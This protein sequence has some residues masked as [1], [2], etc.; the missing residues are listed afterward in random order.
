[1]GTNRKV[2]SYWRRRK[3]PRAFDIV[4]LRPSTL[5]R[6][7]RFETRKALKERLH[8]ETVL[9]DAGAPRHL[10]EYLAECRAGEYVCER[11][12]CQSCARH[13]LA[14]A[15]G[16]IIFNANWHDASNA[17]P[18]IAPAAAS[19]PKRPP[20]FQPQTSEGHQS[21]WAPSGR[22]DRW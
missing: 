10:W 1:M 9:R 20:A 3:P 14:I 11:T 5:P 8:S 7:N 21:G 12:F 2:I 13:G 17:G 22:S 6:G 18:S 15:N 4:L 19:A 16:G